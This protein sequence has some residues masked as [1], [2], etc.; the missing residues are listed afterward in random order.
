MS[1]INK[2]SFF[3]Y[4]FDSN[5]IEILERFA[6]INGIEDFDA[7]D[8][9]HDPE[10]HKDLLEDEVRFK[11]DLD[12][13]KEENA[14]INKMYSFVFLSF[15]LES[16]RQML[17]RIADY[18]DSLVGFILK[19]EN[20]QLDKYSF[21][22]ISDNDPTN[23]KLEYK[24]NKLSVIMLYKAMFDE[25]IIDV[26]SKNQKNDDTNLRLYVDSAN[27]YYLDRTGKVMKVKNSTRQFADVTNDFKG[28]YKSQEIKL[29]NLILE[30]FSKRKERLLESIKPKGI[31]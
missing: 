10:T 17:K 1:P 16:S 8:G 19:A 13:E 9:N 29:I 11:L 4:S 28:E 27:I 30:K 2:C 23:L 5:F 24:L 26:D 3:T 18:L 21:D 12:T 31:N 14:E 25:G 20:F 6:F 15:V 7:Y 22:E